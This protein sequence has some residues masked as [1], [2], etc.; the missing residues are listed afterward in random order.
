MP[1]GQTLEIRG[2]SRHEA[3]T[4]GNMSEELIE[5]EVHC[6][7]YGTNTPLD[8]ARKWYESAP[9]SAVQPILKAISRLSGLDD[10]GKEQSGD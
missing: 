8:E 5:I 7:S 4:I 3:I 1:D 10:L 9:V 6:L 2:L